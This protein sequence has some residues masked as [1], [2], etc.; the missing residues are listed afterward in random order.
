MTFFGQPPENRAAIHEEIFNII[1]FGQ[2]FTHS[3]V[4]NMPLPLRRYYADVLIK[5]K[6]REN[7]EVEEANKQFQDPRLTKN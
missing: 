2:G 7:K 5:T 3:D 6:E 4:Y 1:Y